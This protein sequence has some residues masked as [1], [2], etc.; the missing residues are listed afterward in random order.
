MITKGINFENWRPQRDLNPCYRLER[1]MSSAELDDGDVS[2]E[3]RWI[4]TND[5]RLKRALLY[6]LS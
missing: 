4:R 2:G 5:P 6:Q 1:A 3:P